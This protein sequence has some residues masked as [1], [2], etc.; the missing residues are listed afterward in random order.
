MEIAENNSR[1]LIRLINDILDIEKIGSGRMH[2]ESVPARSRARMLEGA[3]E[4]SQG[5]AG[6]KNVRL[7][8]AA[9]GNAR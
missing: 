7:D 5:L 4:G 8:A 9:P 3:I 2:F 1:R 6:G